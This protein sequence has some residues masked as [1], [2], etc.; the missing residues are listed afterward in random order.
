MNPRIRVSANIVAIQFYASMIRSAFTNYSS[1]ETAAAAS[2]PTR[3]TACPILACFFSGGR[4]GYYGRLVH[5]SFLS[6]LRSIMPENKPHRQI[7]PWIVCGLVVW[8]IYLAVGDFLRNHNLLRSLTTI[9][10]VA[11]F[12]AVW[13]TAL[14]IRRGRRDPEDEEPGECVPHT[15]HEESS[16]GA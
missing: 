7:I 9:V 3:R 14:A 15:P 1:S 16:R 2:C 5:S 11:I 10:C 13:L 6:F 4:Y 8:G 12:L